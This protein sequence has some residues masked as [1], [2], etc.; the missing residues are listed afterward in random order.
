MDIMELGYCA[1]GSPVLFVRSGRNE[2]YFRQK[3]ERALDYFSELSRSQ[4]YTTKAEAEYG[5]GVSKK[6]MTEYR[7][8]KKSL[9]EKIIDFFTYDI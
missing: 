7:K 5:K 1:D 6:P 9:L 2:V 3:Q 4:G 8:P